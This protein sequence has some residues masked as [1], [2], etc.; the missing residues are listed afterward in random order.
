MLMILLES[1]NGCCLSLKECL[2]TFLLPSRLEVS[3]GMANDK[4]ASNLGHS[5]C[6]LPI[7]G[8]NIG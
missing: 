3:V 5:M 4:F 2:F 6:S 1:S 7:N 8:A